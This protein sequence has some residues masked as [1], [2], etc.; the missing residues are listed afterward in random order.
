[1]STG[2]GRSFGANILISFAFTGLMT[3]LSFSN[4]VVIARMVGAEGRGLYALAVA[5][6]G[7]G[8]PLGNL[9]LSFSSTWSL[10]QGRS[11]E[12]VASLNHVWAGL[13]LLPGAMVAG[14]TLWWFGGLP[15][16]EW[17][18][19]AIACATT[20]PSLIYL[21]TTRHVFLGLNQVIRYN[22]VQLSTVTGLLVANSLLL[23]WGPKAVLLTLVVAHWGPTTFLLLAHLPQVARAVLPSREFV[24]ESVRYGVKATGSQIVEVLLLKMDYLLVT[25]IVGMVAIGLFSVADQIATVLA[26]GGLIAGR[27]ML[28]QSA[29]DPTGEQSRR[30]LGLSVRTLLVVVGSG[31]LVIGATGY[32]LGP[33]VFG[34]EFQAAVPGV[35]LLLPTALI[36]GST[37]LIS[38]HL[39]GRNVI[40]PVLTAG[41]VSV[42]LMLVF[43]PLAALAFGWLGVAVVRV[44]VVVVQLV[45]IV[46]ANGQD[47][48]E[49]MRWI[50][51]GED[52]RSLR[53]WLRA[54]LGRA[55]GGPP[56]E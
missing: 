36:R 46:R 10:G 7:I 27:M 56:Q 6:L 53:T 16:A 17:A 21:D 33:G 48:G 30:K 3:V 42:G 15:E 13:L 14:G 20:L 4:S 44:V 19:V 8:L 51:N 24:G 28:A 41:I 22:S 55:G 11:V 52:Y 45:L 25:P 26:W 18:L 50:F 38:G 32:W 2:S 37:G 54:R 43:S 40:K 1:M 34:D 12:E 47:S 23:G 5:V 35:L 49:R 39:I 29:A 31:A 9:G